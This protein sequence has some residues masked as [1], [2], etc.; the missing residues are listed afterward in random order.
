MT[1]V[2]PNIVKLMS[3]LSVTIGSA[4][5]LAKSLN[6]Y[7]QPQPNSKVVGTVDTQVG[8]MT[9]FTP[10][11]SEWTKVADPRNGNVGWVMSKEL[12]NTGVT[13]NVMTSG[14]GGHS[15]RYYQYGGTETYSP[16]KMQKQYDD[17]MKRQRAIQSNMQ[18]MMDDMFQTFYY[19]TPMFVPV[20][21]VPVEK[22]TNK[23]AKPAAATQAPAKP[24]PQKVVE[25]AKDKP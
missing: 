7:E 14:D 23:P 13:F 17:M 1:K 15:Y 9:I 18:H 21:Y 19:P 22:A 5:C 24:A 6:L 11:G 3:V 16:E 10:K 12:G 2:I 20:V 25:P 4:N 8:V